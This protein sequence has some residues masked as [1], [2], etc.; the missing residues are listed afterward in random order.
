MKFKGTKYNDVIHGV[1][2]DDDLIYGL[3]GDDSLYGYAGN[4]KIFGDQGS[5]RLYGG[6]GNDEIHGGSGR[7]YLFGESG[8]DTLIGEDGDDFLFGNIGN[9]NLSG[10]AGN[11]ELWGGEGSSTY[12]PGA[13][14]DRIYLYDMGIDNSHDGFVD[15]IVFEE[16][17]KSNLGHDF[18]DG[19][20]Y[21]IDIIKLKGYSQD[22]LISPV[23]YQEI[24]HNTGD[25][26]YWTWDA[27]ID[28][29]DGTHVLI[30]G[31]SLTDPSFEMG[32][33]YLFL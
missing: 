2:G 5:D 25:G 17:K 3:S 12:I 4:D 31:N 7:D 20:E 10:G 22:D 11:D 21:G 1:N 30:S 18:V 26:D 15:T 9:N 24:H 14:D 23:N 13:G 33:D 16:V 32:R 8:N 28:L 19:F 6:E 29:N 27:S